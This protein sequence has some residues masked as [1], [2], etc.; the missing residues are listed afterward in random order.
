MKKVFAVLIPIFIICAYALLIGCPFYRLTGWRC[1]FCGMTRAYLA[2]FQEGIDGAIREH[3]LFFLGVPTLF[4]LVWI[5]IAKNKTA[6]RMAT[7]LFIILFTLL[8]RNTFH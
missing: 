2:F 6:R 8:F 7:V 5:S 1:P 4:L 3:R